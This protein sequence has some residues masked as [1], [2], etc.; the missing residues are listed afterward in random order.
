MAGTYLLV[1][2]LLQQMKTELL[3]AQVMPKV[4][5]QLSSMALMPALLLTL[6]RLVEV[7]PLWVNQEPL[8]LA[9]VQ[10]REAFLLTE[11]SLSIAV[12]E[13]STLMA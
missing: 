9:V 2:A 11:M 1:A 13:L 7:F 4:V 10:V 3:A 12:Q 5:H 6:I 8:V